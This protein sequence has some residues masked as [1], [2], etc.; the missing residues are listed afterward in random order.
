[1]ATFQHDP[2]HWAPSAMLTY[3]ITTTNN[4]GKYISF[5][6]T[7]TMH[8]NETEAMDA[9]DQTQRHPMDMPFNKRS[10]TDN[11]QS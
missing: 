2:Q 6:H 5:N 7:S 1:M 3:H 10:L 8:D 4:H 9:L 11:W